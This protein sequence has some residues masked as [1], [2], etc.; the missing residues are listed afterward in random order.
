[1]RL[2][3]PWMSSMRRRLRI[4]VT[5]S[6]LPS[7]TPRTSLDDGHD[8]GDAVEDDALAGGVQP[9][10]SHRGR[11]ARAMSPPAR[12]GYEG[13]VDG[14]DDLWVSRR[15]CAPGLISRRRSEKAVGR[16]AADLRSKAGQPAPPFRAGFQQ[17]KKTIHEA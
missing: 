11:W 16:P 5:S 10:A 4:E 1:M 6:W 17:S 9:S 14:G 3:M 2:R 12:W 15:P 13:L 7:T 8:A